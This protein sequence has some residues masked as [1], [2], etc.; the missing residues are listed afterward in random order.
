MATL[1]GGEVGLDEGGILQALFSHPFLTRSTKKYVYD[2]KDRLVKEIVTS[3]TISMGDVIVPLIA[4]GVIT[5]SVFSIKAVSEYL[6]GLDTEE[7]VAI[8]GGWF[9]QAVYKLRNWL[10]EHR[11]LPPVSY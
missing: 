3:E 7:K 8:A 1:S 10:G 4:A 9:P 11:A 6:G 5:L 2:K